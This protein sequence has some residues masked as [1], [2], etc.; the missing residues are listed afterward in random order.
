[1]ESNSKPKRGDIAGG[2]IL[3]FIGLIFLVWQLAPDFFSTVLGIHFTWPLLII[4]L[5][6]IFLLA[7]IISFQ[8]GF[9]V[10]ASILGGIGA[11]LYYQNITGDWA[12]WAYIWAL[13]PGF[14]GLG[15]LL[16][17]LIDR[18]MRAARKPGLYM[19]LISL[20]VTTIFGA[21]FSANV[22][23]DYAWP[24]ILIVAGLI[25]LF[26]GIFRRR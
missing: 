11:I 18:S 23:F 1:M 5:G 19:L 9:L 10:P 14:V 8:G 15:M 12:S 25:F 21:L 24:L 6:G 4:G 26:Q 20:G 22:G 2:L 3:V 7:A 16:G 13:I 17:G